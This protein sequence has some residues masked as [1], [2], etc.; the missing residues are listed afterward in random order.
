MVTKYHYW[1]I[2]TALMVIIL[3]QLSKYFVKK[4]FMQPVTL[5]SFFS[6]VTIQNSGAGFGVLQGKRFFLIIISLVVITLILLY[7]KNIEH[8]LMPQLLWAL[9]LGG[10]V[11]NFID[12]L[13]V[14]TVTDFLNVTFWPAFNIADA[15]I[16][17]GV[18]GMIF[19]YWKK[20]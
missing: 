11:G 5:T 20:K 13:F 10:A 15:S 4:F 19:Y 14:G 3:D 1:F 2:S 18:I 17:I 7:Y 16:T 12:R 6:I 8:T 9:I